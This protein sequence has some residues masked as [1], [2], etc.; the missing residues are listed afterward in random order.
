MQNKN[1]IVGLFSMLV[2]VIFGIGYSY[3]DDVY[4]YE[5]V[6]STSD[7]S[8]MNHAERVEKL[9]IPNEYIQNMT[10]TELLNSV[11]AYPYFSDMLFY[12]NMQEGFY[13]VKEHFNGLQELL[14][15][16]DRGEVLLSEYKV[17]TAM[18]TARTLNNADY[19]KLLF[20]ETILA[21]PEM[22]SIS[23][24]QQNEIST[25]VDQNY[26]LELE[27]PN[28]FSESAYYE[29]LANQQGIDLQSY[30]SYVTTPRGSK[31]S[32]TISSSSDSDA[33]L[34]SNAYFVD[35]IHTYY[36]GASIVAAASDWYN[37]HGFAWAQSTFVWMN[38]PSAYWN[39]GRYSLKAQGQPTAVGQKVTYGGTT[40]SGIVI[41]LSGNCIR[42]KWGR[43]NLVD[44]S[45]TNCPYYYAPVVVSYYN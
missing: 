4:N 31:V 45:V 10:T 33:A 17:L 38:D 22:A 6:I 42:S 11:L 23:A 16:A 14:A 2:V 44:H 37:C 12:D 3:A 36:P 39:D 5:S 15:R 40:H 29:I 41:G 9:S 34:A 43:M 7:W 1:I 30:S 21:Q 32:V 26:Q 28:F 24:E 35:Y 25:L 19:F 18:H 27:A 8:N 13:A 20:L